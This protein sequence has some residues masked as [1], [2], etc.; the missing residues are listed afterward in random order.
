MSGLV[1]AF[2]LYGTL[3]STDSIA[4]HLTKICGDDAKAKQTTS[5]WRRYQLEYSWRIT[6][7]GLYQPFSTL[8]EAALGHAAAETGILLKPDDIAALMKDYDAL[9][10]YPD[11]EQG[12]HQLRTAKSKQN[13]EQEVRCLIFSNGTSTAVNASMASSQTLG[14]YADMFEP[15]LSGA[16]VGA[17]KPARSVY[18]HLIREAAKD[19]GVGTGAGGDGLWLVSANPF[20]VVGASASGIKVVW[21]DRAGTGWIDGLGG[22]I[23]EGIKPTHVG[24]GVDEAVRWIL[25]NSSK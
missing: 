24:S 10:A 6:A 19:S 14:R 21:I 15:P 13:G 5:L 20:D 17:F 22:A 11:V 4:E 1:I 2:D 7:M 9:Q 25:E 12:M 23:G 18:N 16:D 3:L 8:T